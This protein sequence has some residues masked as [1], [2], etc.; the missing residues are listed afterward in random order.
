MRKPPLLDALWDQAHTT[1]TEINGRWYA[2][3]PIQ[4]LDIPTLLERIYHAWLIL[5]GRA[6]ASQYAEDH[7]NLK[8]INYK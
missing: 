3:K 7:F 4:L 5:R 6:I 2:A 8:K 1:M